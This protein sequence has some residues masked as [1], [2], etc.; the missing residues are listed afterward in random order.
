MIMENDT[1]AE[2]PERL[3]HPVRN[4]RDALIR[5]KF[6]GYMTGFAN[7]M[8]L[9]TSFRLG[10][11]DMAASPVSAKEISGKAGLDADLTVML[12]D[13]LVQM[14][15]LDRVEGGYVDS[16][17]AS[18]YLCRDSDTYQ[19]NTL[20]GMFDNMDEWMHLEERLTTG[21]RHV[22]REEMFGEQ[23]LR[24]I[25]ESC[26]DG[27]V[28]AIVDEIDSRVDLSGYRTLLDLGGGHGLH[29]IGLVHKH[30]NLEAT[31]FDVPMMCPIAM[32]NSERYGVPL[33][34]IAGDF[35]KDDLGGPYDVVYSSFNLSTSD[36]RM[37]DRVH[38]AVADGGLLILRRHLPATSQDS[39]R[40]L[41][42]SLRTWDGKGKKNYGGS[43]LPT[44]EAYIER[45]IGLGMSMLVREQMDGSSEL[46]IMT[47]NPIHP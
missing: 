32:K 14:G 46:V 47:K 30:P 25:A 22:R 36:I 4:D 42:W 40:N 5:G 9:R 38:G 45:L 13:S 23:W 18:A 20:N 31:V 10:L 1:M 21:P 27:S 11:F 19:G 44:A 35:Y 29:S 7:A 6:G 43:W 37:A 41:E 3:M 17:V 34:T 24:A 16:D 39:I 12:C 28:G 33:R 26:L 8:I 2:D 15:L